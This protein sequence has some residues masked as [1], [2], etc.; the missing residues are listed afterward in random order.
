MPIKIIGRK[1]NQMELSYEESLCCSRLGVFIML[2][3]ICCPNCERDLF[4]PDVIDEPPPVCE[5]CGCA[6]YG[7]DY[8][9]SEALSVYV[10]RVREPP[11]F[12]DR[13]TKM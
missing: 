8:E 6:L 10:L 5:E 4:L 2:V 3:S 13:K 7:A 11:V 12:S 9:F 1:I